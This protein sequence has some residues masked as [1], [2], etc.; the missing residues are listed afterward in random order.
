MKLW[1]AL[2]DAFVGWLMILR[3]DP[4]WRG[5][6]KLTLPGLATA[7]AIFIFAVFLAVALTSMGIGLPGMLSVLAAMFALALPLVALAL[8]FQGTRMALNSTDPALDVIVP[9][10]YAL[11]AFLVLEGLLAVLG[12]PVVMLAWVALAYILYRLARAATAWNVAISAGFAVLTVVLL[13]ALRLALYMVS[14]AGSPT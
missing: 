7:L 4:A 9:A 6:F 14:S 8:V 10:T 1:T 2:R 11:I 5:Q 3:G 12:G 13:V